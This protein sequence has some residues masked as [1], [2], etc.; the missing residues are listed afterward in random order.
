MASFAEFTAESFH[1]EVG[2][3]WNLESLT[4]GTATFEVSSVRVQ[5]S[6]EQREH[7][8]AWHV[9]F[10]VEKGEQ[11][12]RT[13]LAFHIFNGVFQA[14]REFVGVREP[15]VLVFA[16]K[17]EGL[18]SIYQTYLRRERAELERLGYEW[19]EPYTEFVLRRTRPSG[20]R[21]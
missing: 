19:Q 3:V 1:S 12:E 11:A 8:G 14:V 4:R 6:F 17:R 21:G 9:E 5:V 7:G 13:T 15:D 20:W 10:D 18:S 2:L 16:A